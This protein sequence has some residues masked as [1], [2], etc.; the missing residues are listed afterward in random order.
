MIQNNMTQS[1][2]KIHHSLVVCFQITSCP[3]SIG[4][5]MHRFYSTPRVPC[6][7]HPV[8][9]ILHLAPCALRL[10]TDLISSSLS[11][12]GLKLWTVPLVSMLIWSPSIHWFA[13]CTAHRLRPLVLGHA[14]KILALEKKGLWGGG[15]RGIGRAKINYA[16]YTCSENQFWQSQN[17]ES[18]RYCITSEV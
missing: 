13:H 12:G 8:H 3:C 7:L 14:F 18:T 17:F 1:W 11:H 6:T 5:K 10:Q 4:R 2:W 16:E 9:C 15:V